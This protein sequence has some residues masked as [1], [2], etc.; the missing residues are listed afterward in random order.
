[1]SRRPLGLVLGLALA[2]AALPS[3]QTLSTTGLIGKPA[4]ALKLKDLAGKPLDLAAY[5]GK[6][7]IVDFWATWCVPCREE[8]PSFNALAK[9]YGPK[10]FA[11]IGVSMDDSTEP[12]PAFVKKYAVGYPV[13]LGDIAL[14]D[15]F[16]GILGLP[17]AFVIDR[18]G[19]VRQRYDGLTTLAEFDRAVTAALGAR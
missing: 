8:I 15:R 3:A 7:V 17:V 18:G 14:A 9:K 19:I 12:I 6:V 16:G 11:V 2:V 10:D 13:A 4:P 5:K 1:M